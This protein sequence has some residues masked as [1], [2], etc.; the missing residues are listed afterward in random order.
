MVTIDNLNVS[1][2]FLRAKK[3]QKIIL[4]LWFMLQFKLTNGGDYFGL[5]FFFLPESNGGG[6]FSQTRFT[7]VVVIKPL[8]HLEIRQL[9]NNVSNISV[10]ADE[11]LVDRNQPGHCRGKLAERGEPI[12]GVY[13][14]GLG[15]C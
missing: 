11:T 10:Q 9:R 15:P 8:E 2:C 7:L 13:R 1:I 4:L 12:D 14:H 3:P 5:A 6:A